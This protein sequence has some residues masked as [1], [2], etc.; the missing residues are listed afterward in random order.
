MTKNVP[1][2]PFILVDGSSYLFRA[3][4]APPHLTNSKGEPTG[5]IYGVVNMLR[6]LLKRYKPENM[7]VVFDAKGKTFRSDIYAEYKAHRPPMPD[8]LRSQI[9]PL[10]E[11]V[12]AM[13]LPL[14]CVD[15]VEADDVIGTLATQ[16]SEE[17]RFTLIST[18]DKDMA[19]LVNEHVMLINTMTDT[20]L[21]EEGVKEKFG[22]A[23]DQIIDYLALMGDSSDNIPGLPKV[24]EKTAQALLQGIPSI[25]AIY[26]DVDAVTKLSFRG[27][28]SMPKKLQEYR[29]QLLMSRELATIKCDVELDFNPQQLSI[30]A[31]DN[32]KLAEL[33]GRCEF[34]RWLSELLE[35]GAATDQALGLT[36]D[37]D[38]AP[39]TGVSRDGYQTLL[40]EDEVSEYLQKLN[41]LDYF[42]F[43]TETTSLNYMD[44]ELVGVS[45]SGAEGEGVYIPVAHDYMEAPEQVSRDWLLQQLKPLLEADKPQKVG[46]N[47]KYDAHILRRYDI[48]LAGIKNDTMLASYVFNS[49]GSRHDMDTLSLQYL[50]HKPIKF[51]DIAGKGAK[52][53][54]FNQIALEQAA[55]YAAEDADI[56]LRL[57]EVLWS[58]LES[59]SDELM[60]VL[61]DIEIP[62]I[63]V[64]TDMEEYGV[65]IDADMLAQQSHDIEKL[66]VEYERK[67]FEI[68]GEEFN[69]GSTKQLQAILF[70]KLQLPVIKK[71]PKGAPSTAEDVLH[72]LA[73]D[74]PLPDVILRHRSLSKLKSTYTDKLP[75]MINARTGR[76]HT[77]YQQA[78]AATGRLSSTEPNLQNI[79]IRTEEG[80]R[81]RQ[82]FVPEPGYKIVAIDYSQIELRIMAHL[83]QDKALLTA[84]AEG[85]D[86]HRATA[87]EV[88]SC[89][90]DE[91]SDEQRRRAKAVNFGLI[92]GMSA[93]GLARQLDIPRHEAQHYMDKYFERFPGVLRYMEDT[94]KLAK[95][96]GFVKT[97]YGRRLP[98]P[99]IK[100]SNG[101]RRKAAERAAINA[102]MQGTAA[103]IIKRAMIAV[104]QW[105]AE[106][107]CQKDVRMLMQVH[108]ELVFEIAEHKID[109]YVSA[110]SHVMEQAASLDVPLI[111]EAGVGMNWDE[112]H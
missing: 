45:L 61:T 75:K 48:R 109:D 14:L 83:S 41:T 40:S 87:A 56:T 73:H 89:S 23:P 111:A 104:D 10:H 101:A 19:Q 98:L 4:H 18:S 57:H 28:K 62:L 54:T 47:L 69:L 112:A 2:N 67:A 12:K 35:Q 97:L 80:R 17:G 91:V 86:I 96:Q 15:G 6:S 107:Q 44:A 78:V 3:F 13:G 84:F 88:F 9:E 37:S 55:P 42:A 16:A 36:H 7:A 5:A 106:K 52:Q 58:K 43:D 64:L 79:P 59:T 77:S 1:E 27:A 94:R 70:D 30:S 71:T 72:E 39:D 76:V 92:Y 66:L 20:L 110:L 24:G 108:D 11:I 68:A 81:V 53:L 32:D 60:H 102:P 21:D 8:E 34:R 65:R 74:Y 90:L 85:K 100:A 29:D 26:D 50:N 51:E 103:D 82:A 99:D 63:S 22:V 93:F 105:I 49:V 38:D 46:Q 25:D 95:E 31:A 33:Y